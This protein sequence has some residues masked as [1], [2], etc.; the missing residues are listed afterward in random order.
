MNNKNNINIC[1]KL[2]LLSSF[3]HDYCS[4]CA[5]ENTLYYYIN[6]ITKPNFGRLFVFKRLKDAVKHLT[7]NRRILF[8]EC[9]T[10]Q[11][12]NTVSSSSDYD[13]I[14]WTNP[15]DDLVFDTSE[16]KFY[17]T[18]WVKPLKEIVL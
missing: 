4:I 7:H 13:T 17:T 10:L 16:E 9:G 8:C 5:F 3:T 15:I 6:Y 12:Q 1:Y 11:K 2:V 18:E 14:F